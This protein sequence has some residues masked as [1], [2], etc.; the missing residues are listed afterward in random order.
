MIFFLRIQ[1]MLMMLFLII[2][3]ALFH[4]LS[5]LLYLH[6]F[7]NNIE[8]T[9][10]R[11]SHIYMNLFLLYVKHLTY[12]LFAHIP[13]VLIHNQLCILL[14]Q[15][16][17]YNFSNCPA[18]L[19]STNYFRIFAFIVIRY[20]FNFIIFKSKFTCVFSRFRFLV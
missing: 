15:F 18:I 10:L 13:Q 14:R 3:Q 12:F 11:S 17:P 20:L 7:F 16:Y 4:F 2:A 9:L 5:S 1:H 19:S 8:K 6:L